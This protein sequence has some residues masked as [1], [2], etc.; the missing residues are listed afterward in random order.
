MIA[1]R[2]FLVFVFALTSFAEDWPQWLGPKRDGI[3][4]E[5]G[6]LEKFPA[7]GPKVLWRKPINGGYSGPAVANGRVYVM[8]RIAGP[9]LERKPG[10]RGM[11]E[12]IGEERVL[13][14]DER[15]G[16]L[17][18]EHKYESR[19]RIDFPSGPRTTPTIDGERVYTLGA[20][21]DLRCLDAKDG[22]LVWAKNFPTEYEIKNPQAWGW[23]AH[24]LIHGQKIICMVGGTNTAVVAF[25]KRSGK[26]LWRAL[27]THEIGY[28]PPVVATVAGKEQLIVWHTEALAGLRPDSGELIWSVPYPAEGKHQRPEV[29]IGMPR[30]QDGLVFVT[31]FYHG[32]LMLKFAGEKAELLWNKKSTSRSSFNAGLHTTMTTPVLKEGFIYGVCGGGTL[33]CLNAKTGERVWETREHVNGKETMFGT[34]FLIQAGEKTDRF[35]IWTDLGDLILARLTPEKY[36]EISRAH[37][38]DPIEN[39]R[40]REVVWSHP[41]FA[42]KKFF[43]RNQK[44]IICVSLGA[45]LNG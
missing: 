41:A 40:G 26:E 37:L 44:E 30:V 8:D 38:L 20:M 17:I 21:G 42:D 39:A 7:D 4:R 32:G 18:W 43:A 6:L 5:T 3:V 14:L 12:L 25:D 1:P 16:D 23:A 34:S 28:A 10:E 9:P 36:E 27:T 24:P 45:E 31:S 35:F 11:P 33:R 15:T 29:T 13:C 22:S 2:I 19:Y